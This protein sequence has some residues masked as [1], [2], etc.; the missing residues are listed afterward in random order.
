[1]PQIGSLDAL[2]GVRLPGLSTNALD[3][4]P[5]QDRPLRL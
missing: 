4:E 3:V 2:T 1:M 5:W